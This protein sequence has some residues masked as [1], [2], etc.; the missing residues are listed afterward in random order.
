[1]SN[2]GRNE[3]CHCGSGKKYKKCCMTQD[4]QTARENH[5]SLVPPLD[6]SMPTGRRHSFTYDEL[7]NLVDKE[8]E[9]SNPQYPALAHQLIESMKNEYQTDQMAMA[10]MIWHEYSSMM[11][12]TFRK[13]GIFCAVLEYMVCEVNGIAKT[14]T[15]LAEKYDVSAATVSKRF[16]DMSAFLFEQVEP[17][18]AELSDSTGERKDETILFP[19]LK[20]PASI[21]DNKREQAKL[22]L[23]KANEAQNRA[24]RVELILQS[25]QLNPNNC[26]AYLQLA[27][28]VDKVENALLYLKLGVEAG[29]HDLG[30]AFIE[31]TRGHFWLE[32]ST[33]PYMRIKFE[34]ADVCWGQYDIT[35]ATRQL[36]DIL[37]LNPDDNMGARYLLSA[38]YLDQQRLDD[39]EKLLDTY[40]IDQTAFF[41]YDRFLL[42][43]FRN[44]LSAKLKLMY[45]NAKSTNKYVPDYIIGK[46][47]LPVFPPDSY[48]HGDVNEAEYYLDSHYQLIV[49]HPALLKWMEKQ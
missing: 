17:A 31:E 20:P 29:E 11:K 40:A 23:M 33:R 12:P 34:Y 38:V 18:L 37:D 39:A 16:Q 19:A 30:Q 25:L 26:E 28:G 6:A 47:T 15:E 48:G 24:D 13:M 7:I 5:L 42:E 14:Q 49:Q 1:M 43:Y 8:M 41:E 3:P 35:E 46:K 45:R 32:Y 2:L 9:W 27:Q 21:S 44:G 10:I 4:E 22:L 36:E